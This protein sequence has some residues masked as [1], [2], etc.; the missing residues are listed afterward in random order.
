MDSICSVTESVWAFRFLIALALI[1]LMAIVSIL[2]KGHSKRIAVIVLIGIVCLTVAMVIQ[3]EWNIFNTK[4]RITEAQAEDILERFEG[5]PEALLA[6]IEANSVPL[7]ELDEADPALAAG[8][9]AESVVYLYQTDCF[10]WVSVSVKQT[11]EDALNT[12][13]YSYKDGRII[14]TLNDTRIICHT[15][16]YSRNVHYFHYFPVFAG[17]VS[18]TEGVTM[19]YSGYEFLFASS[20]SFKSRLCLSRYFQLLAEHSG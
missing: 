13:K 7:S 10:T 11:Q 8:F 20:S 2:L 19:E 12:E 4:P 15:I 3:V 18:Y 6:A 1:V 9:H 5:D 16:T 17:P 14:K